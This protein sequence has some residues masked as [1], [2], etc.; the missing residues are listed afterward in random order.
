MMAR[1]FACARTRPL[2]PESIKTP[3]RNPYDV[4]GVSKTASE[5]D[6]KKAFRR[7]AKK[8]H[9]DR[10]SEDPKAKEKFAEAN[11]ANDILGDPAK[12][13]QFDRGEID[14]EGKPRAPQFEGFG[15]G[16]GGGGGQGFG[17]GFQREGFSAGFGG[18]RARAG[19]DIFSE[20]FKGF[21]GRSPDVGADFGPDPREMQGADLEAEISVSLEDVA[22]GATRRVALPGG[23]ELDVKIP[24]GVQDGQT[25][26]LRGQGRP[27][28][29]GSGDLLLKIRYAPHGVFKVE[30]RDLLL[31]LDVPLADAYLGGS[32]RV[33]TLTGAIELTIP[34]HTDGGKTFRLR[35]KGLPGKDPAGSI[36]AGKETAGKDASANGDLKV[37]VNIVLPRADPDLEAL[38]R[39]RRG[40]PAA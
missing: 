13:A 24:L 28:P 18:G 15:P 32:V 3:M 38:L 40:T 20:I 8:Y 21:A 12:R 5:A 29:R 35:G 10:N 19:A 37:T 22:A 26:R 16:F 31:K 30:G 4:L 33:P 23:R 6:I 11:N 39:K 1:P 14:A 27:G 7:L 34:P 2:R 36:P 25:I 17:G 9:P